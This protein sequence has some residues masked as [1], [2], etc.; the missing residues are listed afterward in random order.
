LVIGKAGWLRS[1]AVAVAPVGRL[2]PEG[3]EREDVRRDQAAG[4]PKCLANRIDVVN[5]SNSV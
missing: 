3:D 4:G 1:C 2:Q 5:V